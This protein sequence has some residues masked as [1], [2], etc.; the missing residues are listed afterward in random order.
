MTDD[1]IA[2][3]AFWK[4]AP[5]SAYCCSRLKYASYADRSLMMQAATRAASMAQRSEFNAS[6]MWQRNWQA[7]PVVFL[8]DEA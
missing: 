7:L 2:F 5:T 4:R 3:K 1:K 6:A 8:G